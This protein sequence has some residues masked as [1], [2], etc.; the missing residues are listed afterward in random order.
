MAAQP[1]I[2]FD[3]FGRSDT[4]APVET[5]AAR[6]TDPIT[7]HLAAE[8]H[9]ASGIR[10][11]QQRRALAAVRAIPGLTSFELALRSG[12]DRYEL[13]RRL[14]ELRISKAV[15]N[16]QVDDDELFTR[17][18]TV[19]GKRAMEWWPTNPTG[20]QAMTTLCIQE[21][22]SRLS[23]ARAEAIRASVKRRCAHYGLSESDT[24]RCVTAAM[25]DAHRGV[26]AWT[27]IR[28]AWAMAKSLST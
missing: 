2:Q 22:S 23:E 13:G 9:T 20:E 5:P 6:H 8:E 18:C 11:E 17:R 7:S 14:P 10:G 24:K 19:S 27:A 16:P 15:F 26:S 3:F 28:A 1:Q 25:T 4:T 12:I 21:L